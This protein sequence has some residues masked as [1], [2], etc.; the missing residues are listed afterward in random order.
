MEVNRTSLFTHHE[1]NI[2]QAGIP[3]MYTFYKTVKYTYFSHTYGKLLIY[4]LGGGGMY[5]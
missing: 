3:K 5:F 2:H 4:I 1:T